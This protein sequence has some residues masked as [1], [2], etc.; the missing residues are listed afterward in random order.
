[1]QYNGFNNGSLRATFAMLEPRGWKSKETVNYGLKELLHCGFIERTR[2]G[3]RF[4]GTHFPSL[5][6]LT[7]E[8]QHA[9][10]VDGIPA[11]LVPS[12]AWKADHERFLRPVRKKKPKGGIR[13]CKGRNP[14]LSKDE[15]RP[16]QNEGATQ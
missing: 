4:G 12:D 16:E 11:R 5:Y 6:A 14:S 15:I 1:M 2:K 3:K 13:T 9:N 8:P 7:W 10:D